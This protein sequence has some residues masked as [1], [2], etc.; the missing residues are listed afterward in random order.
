MKSNP[1][2]KKAA[3][4][5]RAAKG[6]AASETLDASIVNELP[7]S[8]RLQE[9]LKRPLTKAELETIHLLN[10]LF[11]RVRAG[12]PL[13]AGDMAELGFL[14]QESAWT[15]L[16]L[17]PSA[18]QD[19]EELWQYAALYADENNLAIPEFLKPVT[20]LESVRS[21]VAQFRRDR[22]VQRWRTLLGNLQLGPSDDA[23]P[24]G[25]I[26]LRMRLGPEEAVVEW[27]RV[28]ADSYTSIKA[29]KFRDFDEKYSSD[30][31]P[32]VAL[33]WQPL[34]QRARY[35]YSVE[36]FYHDQNT[37][38][39]LNRVLR[40]PALQPFIVGST[41]EPLLRPEQPLRWVLGNAETDAD[42]YRLQLTLPDGK[43][44][45]KMLLTLSGRPTLYLSHD[46]VYA[47]PPVEDRVLDPAAETRI[48][49]PALESTAGVKLLA[50]LQTTLPPRLAAKVKSIPL[51]PRIVAE[52]VQP[53]VGYE[54]EFCFLDVLGITPEGKDAERWTG[55]AWQSVDPE[56]E[57]K[58]STPKVEEPLTM[59]D[60]TPLAD[61][62]RLV[63]SGGF[64][65]DFGRQRWALKVTRQFPE[66]FVPWLKALPLHFDL[67]LRGEL[68]TFLRAEV[69]GAIRLEVQ[70]AGMDWFD[71]SVIVD[72]S[73]TS[74]T[75]EEI[76]LLLDAR[77]KW[78]RLAAKGWRKLEF[79]LSRE[80]DEQLARIGL[81]PHELTSEKQRLHAL[82]LADP[83]AKALLSEEHYEKVQRRASELRAS[84]TPPVPD[85][86]KAELRPYQR[87][88][89]HF[90]AYLTTNR[91]G[92]I[93]ADDMGLGK[94]LQTLTWLVWLRQQFA[95]PKASLVVCPKSVAD[96]WRAETNRFAPH[97]RVAVWGGDDLKL[98]P[99]KL[100]TADLHI[101]NYNQ[102]R[103]V[104]EALSKQDLLA[105]VLDE[106][107][108]IKNPGSVT[109]VVAGKLK[110][111]YRLVLSGTPIEN[112]LLDLW[113]LLAFAMP[114]LLGSRAEFQ[115]LFDRKEDPLA[116]RRLAA[117]VR[118]FLL[119]R[120]KTQVAKDLPD[121][122]E[123]DLFCEMEGEQQILYRAELKR[124]QQVLLGITTQALLNK[125]RFNLL[126]SLLRLRQI[127]CHPKLVK[128]ETKAESAKLEALLET[129]DPLIEEGQKVLVFS[130]FVEMLDIVKQA[131]VERNWPHYYLAGSTENRGELVRQFQEHEG[132][133]VFLIS[134]K[135]G[136]FGLN[137][138][139]ASY[140]VLFDPWWNPAVE[141]QAIDRVHRIGQHQT[142]IAYRLLI[143]GSVEEKIRALQQRKTQLAD[144]VLGEDKFA[145]SLTL[146]DLQQ[147]LSD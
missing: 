132:E 8:R 48:P 68:A 42:D 34:A 126:T 62:P 12:Q 2:L 113:S 76:K 110:A 139:A 79:K 58:D 85:E 65:W 22:D 11:A 89:F 60:R 81:T 144:D 141:N 112:K 55:T 142:V 91:F 105:V 27:R 1:S 4:K 47:G 25:Q 128:P 6:S 122:I 118:P 84:V 44:V 88:G 138:T 137:L 29:G 7:F 72:V 123:E 56:P 59:F 96:N 14:V 86:V 37:R 106:G 52:L 93:L 41:G 80:E 107:Q 104:G 94:T 103:I 90:L 146:D 64:R 38:I 3:P 129:L 21:Q 67:E 26:E 77:G 32:E 61:I 15:K 78:V 101:I 117:R 134:L 133:A 120:T 119:R 49:A 140:V 31:A 35:G 46:T 95:Q 28:G 20:R 130:Q 74:L 36:L 108:Y 135:A 18:P 125:N 75:K 147:L 45:S 92:G 63:E 10:R 98:L 9:E 127:C 57:V 51:R 30:I 53:I 13:T 136:G 83:A 5:P 71:L 50:Y 131:L 114:G 102:L 66:R 143:K 100:K 145:Q 124:A 16:V 33:L 69:A 23:R 73:D 54:N 43:P 19:L 115:R 82:Q 39:L 116:R 40:L 99:T 109:A 70:E 97:L 24:G 121:R 87:E 111:G 17:F